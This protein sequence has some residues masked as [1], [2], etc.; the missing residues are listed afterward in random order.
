MGDSLDRV[1]IFVDAGYLFAQGST[2]LSGG[3][4]KPRTEVAL[5][6]KAVIEELIEFARGRAQSCGLLRIYWYDGTVA[7]SKPTSEQSL[8]ANLDDVKLRLGFINSHGQQ[9][10]VD[11]LIVTDLIELSRLRAISDAILLAGDEDLRVGVQIA[12]NYGVRIH[13]LGIVPSSGSQS[14]QLRWEADTTSE[15]DKLKVEKFLSL[16][17]PASQP[18]APPP[19]ATAPMATAVVVATT[20]TPEQIIADEVTAFVAA[21]EESDV[22]GIQAFWKDKVG[23]PS[24][25]DR[26]MLVKCRAALNRD[27]GTIEKKQMRS[28]FKIEAKKLVD[29][30]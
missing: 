10:G 13:L 27:L 3:S 18:A 6:P 2:V 16:R 9:K 21:L 5:S 11:S 23:A 28:V 14:K 4:K 1:A 15:W 17:T 30:L 12:Q 25:L 7:G 8:I 20:R 26:I 29:A 22:R 24:D 19:V